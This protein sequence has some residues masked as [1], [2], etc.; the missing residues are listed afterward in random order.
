MKPLLLVGLWSFA[1]IAV[2]CNP[3]DYNSS[4]AVYGG[5]EP[6]WSGDLC[7]S[8]IKATRLSRISVPGY[9]ILFTTADY[10]KA[11]DRT[12]TLALTGEEKRKPVLIVYGYGGNAPSDG[13]VHKAVK[14]TQPWANENFR[15][16]NIPT[17]ADLSKT[18]QIINEDR[19]RNP[20]DYGQDA[21]VG[22]VVAAHG[23]V[24][25]DGRHKTVKSDISEV[26]IDPAQVG[27]T[28]TATSYNT[29]DVQRT[30]L[31]SVGN[32]A[33]TVMCTVYE[34][35]SG[36]VKSDPEFDSI[37]T[38]QYNPDQ[39]RVFQFSSAA[40]R[41]A[42]TSISVNSASKIVSTTS[43]EQSVGFLMQQGQPD[44]LTVDEYQQKLNSAQLGKLSGLKID[45]AY[46][47]GTESDTNPLGTKSHDIV[48]PMFSTQGPSVVGPADAFILPPG[49]IPDTKNPSIAT[50]DDQIQAAT[51]GLPV[52]TTVKPAE[53]TPAATNPQNLPP[54]NEIL[55]QGNSDG[56][57]T[58]GVEGSPA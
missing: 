38:N 14:D 57:Q 41:N 7:A 56:D 27:P 37:K 28:H 16:I 47:P 32:N 39:K 4:L 48:T 3:A 45:T 46:V 5:S 58:D 50:K 33:G 51:T 8:K 19:R 31:N 44:G 18:A 55:P 9:D 12:A 6:A 53:E 26:R 43:I 29:V 34:C 36:R 42:S 24:G 10:C 23:Y 11:K 13:I 40:D 25:D 21:W 35:Q 49:V 2:S 20:T 1:G 15:V 54:P 52:G 17:G 22:S 30:I